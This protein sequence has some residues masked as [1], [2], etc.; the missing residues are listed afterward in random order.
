[1]ATQ[2][3]YEVLIPRSSILEG[4]R[5]L[6][7][8]ALSYVGETLKPEIA[9]VDRDREVW[10]DGSI[11]YYDVLIVISETSPKTDSTM[12]QI[13][14]YVSEATGVSPIYVS[15]QDKTGIQIWPLHFKG[16]NAL[17]DAPSEPA[18]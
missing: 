11:S 6:P 10:R 8:I 3:R 13:G 16:S 1:M 17:S 7:T 14:V 15:K 9:S 4:A 2:S 18:A 5:D 12:K